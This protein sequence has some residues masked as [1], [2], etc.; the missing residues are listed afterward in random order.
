MQLVGSLLYVDALAWLAIHMEDK[1]SLRLS[2]VLPLLVL[3]RS[4]LPIDLY[5]LI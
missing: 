3:D 1:V 2:M 4:T 5:Y